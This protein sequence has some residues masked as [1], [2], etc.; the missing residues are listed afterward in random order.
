[1]A[2]N[3]LKEEIILS[4]KHFD[5]KINSV[6]GQLGKLQRKGNNIGD[7]FEKSVGKMISR[8]TGFNGSMKLTIG[9][10][11][12]VGGAFGIAFG[13]GEVFNRMMTQSQTVG[14]AVARVQNQAS[15]SVNYFASCLARADFSGFISGLENVISKAGEVADALDDLNSAQLLFDFSNQ[16]LNAD[17]EKQ[18]LISKDLTKSEKERKEALEK[19]RKISKDI[20]ANERDMSKRYGKTAVDI[21]STELAKQRKNIGNIDES[22]INKWFSYDKFETRKQLKDAYDDMTKEAERLYRKAENSRKQRQKKDLQDRGNIGGLRAMSFNSEEQSLRK[23]AAD[24]IKRRDSDVSK[25]IAWATSEIDDSTNSKLANALKMMGNQS[26]L[27][28]SAA[29][30]EFQANRSQARL[31]QKHGETAK[32]QTGLARQT[33]EVQAAFDE[34]AVTIKAINDNIGILKKRLETTKPNSAE[35]RKVSD[36]LDRWNYKLD[37]INEKTLIGTFKEN[38]TSIKDINSNISILSQLL[39]NTVKGSSEWHGITKRI[40]EESAKIAEYQKGSIGDLS[41][42]VSEITDRLQNE[43]LTLDA[44]IRLID[45]K[46]DLQAKID[47]LNDDAY[48]TVRP[49]AGDADR[50]LRSVSNANASINQVKDLLDNRIIDSN[51]AK[52]EIDSINGELQ[53]LGLNP[54][55]IHIETDAEKAFTNLNEKFST[56][57]SSFN[58][59]D[60]VVNSVSSLVD[61]INEGTDAWGIFMGT[62]NSGVAILNAIGSVIEATTLLNQ[63]FGASNTIVAAET[64]AA[65]AAQKEKAITDAA[66]STAVATAAKVE[67]TALLDLAA[68]SFFAAHAGIPF[69]GAGLATGFIAEMMGTMTA[70]QAATKALAAFADGGIVGGSSFVGDRVIARVNSGEMILNTMQQKHLF[71]LLDRGGNADNAPAQVQFVIK[72]KDLH[73]VMTN[74][75]KINGTLK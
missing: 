17:Y 39:E 53:K 8:A 16:Q 33:K 19:A 68:A 50:K 52:K 29:Q 71:D 73:G 75:N 41:N 26:Q 18:L 22:F 66:T 6:I 51:Q 1:M 43:N 34:N 31:E 28:L 21:I 13:A 27:D 54:V 7:G 15:E 62:L 4:T 57:Y 74:Y 59:I 47:R 49:L 3:Q 56:F 44:R 61:S 2:Q 12:K 67:E 35:F 69:A 46:N 60:G 48:I 38:A 65:S 72:G 63:L 32:K 36:E 64:V 25:V 37:E 70:T 20:T 55:K 9:T 14:D 40:K 58:S 11:G 5:E 45:K 42:Q 30:R 24:I 10:L 23:Q